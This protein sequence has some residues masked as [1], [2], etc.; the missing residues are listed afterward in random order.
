MAP[1]K[2]KGDL[3]ELKVAADLADRGCSIS[4][5]FG[6]DCDYDL[7]ADFGGILHRVQVKYTESDSRVVSV[8]C[9]SHSL[10]NGRVRRTKRYTAKT[11]D[12]LVVYD[13][14]SDRCYYVPAREL[15][16]GRSQLH[17]RLT[18]ALNGQRTGIRDADLY[19]DPDLGYEEREMEPAGLEPATSRMQTGRSSS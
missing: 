7:I 12:W 8:R 2:Q 13:R 18:P 19:T 6:E 10:T 5:P 17:L 9:H 16:S 3:A 11:V 14:T 1:L 15:G 4:V